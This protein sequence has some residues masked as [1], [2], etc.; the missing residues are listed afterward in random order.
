MEDAV[1]NKMKYSILLLACLFLFPGWGDAEQLP[2]NYSKLDEVYFHE[3]AS[4]GS[5]SFVATEVC[6]QPLP[7]PSDQ[8]VS[9]AFG[10][11]Q[12]TVRASDIARSRPIGLGNA[13]VGGDTFS[14][15]V[16][17]NEFEGPVDLYVAYASAGNP[18]VIYL[19]QPGNV[20][21]QLQSQAVFDT[22]ALGV[23]PG[24]IQPWRDNTVGP[25]NSLLFADTPVA[26]IPPS[27]YTFYLLAAPTGRIDDFFLWSTS[28]SLP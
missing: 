13:A 1:A 3:L 10:P 21:L 25:I 28:I 19:M 15:R 23:L 26:A 17:L 27:D 22:L 18:G 20:F 24:G 6:T 7:V 9:L 16:N 14:V 2:A 12:D 5:N 8:Q 4:S 11:V